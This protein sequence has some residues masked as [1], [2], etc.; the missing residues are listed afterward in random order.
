MA[1]LFAGVVD[2][3]SRSEVLEERR[4]AADLRKR[5]EDLVETAW[6]PDGSLLAD[7]DVTDAW[8]DELGTPTHPPTPPRP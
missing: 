5:A 2:W 3:P 8:W 7:C 1:R 4:A 6:A